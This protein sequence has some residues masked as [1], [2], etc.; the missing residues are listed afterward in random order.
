MTCE[1]SGSWEISPRAHQVLP[2]ARNGEPTTRADRGSACSARVDPQ[3]HW[4][5]VQNGKHPEDKLVPI[6]DLLGPAKDAIEAGDVRYVGLS[7]CTVEQIEAAQR[8][9]PDGKLVSVQNRC[10]P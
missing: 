2:G 4:C 5:Q 3:V 7:N 10:A 6:E 9:L 1:D 8:F